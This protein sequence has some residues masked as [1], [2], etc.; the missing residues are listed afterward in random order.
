[1]NTNT[2]YDNQ[3]RSVKKIVTFFRNGKEYVI[4]HAQMQSGKSDTFMLAGA[5]LVR[6]GLFDRFV[7]ISANADRDLGKQTKDV[8]DFSRRYRKYLRDLPG[9]EG[10]SP[11]DAEETEKR[12]MSSFSVYWGHSQ[13]EKAPVLSNSLV[14][15]D[16]S[17]YGQSD[18]QS[19]DRF[20]KAQELQP[21][22]DAA[23]RGNKILSVSAT[24]FSEMV[25]N[26]S[27]S[28]NKGIVTMEP[29]DGY[30][31][32]GSFVENNCFV[33]YEDHDVDTFRDRV[34][35]LRSSPRNK[36]IVRVKNK[37]KA[38]EFIDQCNSAKISSI[39]YTADNKQDINSLLSDECA[40]VIIV[41]GRMRMGYVIP[42]KSKISF[43]FEAPI[44][45]K[46]RSDTLLQGLV[47]RMCGYPS[48][49]AST[50]IKLYV[51]S[52]FWDN[53]HYQ[54]YADAWD[55]G[56]SIGCAGPA[57]NVR[58]HN[59]PKGDFVPT[60]PEKVSIDF[61]EWTGSKE[62][63]TRFLRDTLTSNQFRDSPRKNNSFVINNLQQ[64]LVNNEITNI[65][66]NNILKPSYTG[67]D[68]TLETHYHNGKE[69]SHN[70][71][72]S[73][74]TAT[75]GREVRF[76]FKP[77][78][79]LVDYRGMSGITFLR[80]CK[81]YKVP[82]NMFLQFRRRFDESMGDTR[83]LLVTTKK[84]IFAH[85]NEE[86]VTTESNGGGAI[87]PL[88][89]ETASDVG[90]MQSELSDLIRDERI[91][92]VQSISRDG[93]SGNYVGIYLTQK[94]WDSLRESGQIYEYIN[95]NFG[96]QLVLTKR[97]GRRPAN[98]PPDYAVCLSSI[99][100]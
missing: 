86:G 34:E 68:H 47:G 99:A 35:Q 83:K 87:I 30:I 15:V 18:K 79:P 1:M 10:L 88:S 63:L 89:P 80:R 50:H 20:F 98:F 81:R 3:V 23:A 69:L 74:N 57:M 28:Q 73:K 100:W 72:S 31:G 91:R 77:E 60:I 75:D 33:D 44:S 45:G 55:T 4:L 36:A 25:D 65:H 8:K 6:L 46:G 38:D 49:G 2:F 62:D 94:V 59:G 14:I 51:P 52:N 54:H 16:E 84:E 11:D 43:I 90:V 82:V 58:C 95:E 93:T 97:R 21:N 12:V 32:I 56:N 41:I 78:S 9:D 92:C 7:V 37:K 19:L 5:E 67:H 40:R 22:G 53:S 64:R 48:T 17:H 39:L 66:I 24:P 42:D 85:H 70:V 29:G 71:G 61:S 13:L 27:F 26:E 76:W 96:K